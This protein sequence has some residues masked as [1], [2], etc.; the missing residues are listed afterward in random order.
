LTII[1][2]VKH[3]NPR[4]GITTFVVAF[5]RLC[6]NFEGVKHL[7]PRQGITTIARDVIFALR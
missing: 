4:Q 6:R 7:N 5:A 2:G 3:L 1:S